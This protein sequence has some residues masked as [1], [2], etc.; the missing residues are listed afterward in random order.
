QPERSA[1]REATS[2]GG[3]VPAALFEER[4]ERAEQEPFG[5]SG[6]RAKRVRSEKRWGWG[7]SALM[8]ERGEH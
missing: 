7:P 2:R 6:G 5:P 4:G 3:G 1:K 8:E